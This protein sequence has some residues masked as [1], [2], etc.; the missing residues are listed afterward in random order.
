MYSRGKGTHICEQCKKSFSSA[1]S[2]YNHR[3]LKHNKGKK[4]HRV[5]EKDSTDDTTDIYKVCLERKARYIDELKQR[6]S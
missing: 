5:A 6:L 2:Y 1:S 4:D 3:S